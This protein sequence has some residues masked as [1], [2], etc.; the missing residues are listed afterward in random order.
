MREK[1][2]RE[3]NKQNKRVKEYRDLFNLYIYME[4]SGVHNHVIRRVELSY[5]R[6]VVLRV[7]Q[8]K[9][10]QNKCGN[11]ENLFKG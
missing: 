3:K 6:A 10:S 1:E 8:H 5:V 4:V 7:T 2:R 11:L 9:K